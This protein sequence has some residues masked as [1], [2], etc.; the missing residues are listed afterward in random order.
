MEE[1][2]LTACRR[3]VFGKAA[4]AKCRSAD[5]LPAVVYDRKGEAIAIDV[6]YRDFEKLFKTVTESTLI[7]IKLDDKDELEVFIKDYQYDIVNDK[8]YH[9]DF[10]AVERGKL[11]RTRIQLRLS[12]SPEVCRHGAVLET[13]ITEVEVECLPR[14]LPER[15]VVD[16]SEMGANESL[17]VKDIVVSP[18]MKILTDADLSVATIKYIKADDTAAPAEAEA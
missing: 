10:Y 12:G 17:H 6:P 7:I 11:L 14:D 8:V 5:R 4:A 16:V 15:I 18:N 2:V 13:G 3:M 9:V 1:R